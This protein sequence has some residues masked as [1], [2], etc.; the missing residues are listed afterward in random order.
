MEAEKAATLARFRSEMEHAVPWTARA[1]ATLEKDHFTVTR[2]HRRPEKPVWFV[3]ASPPAEVQTGFGL[4]PEL[5]FVLVDHEVQA[6]DVRAAAEEVVRSE[7][8]LDGNLMVVCDRGA[9]LQERLANIGG[10]GQRI[11]W[12]PNP[13]GE[14]TSLRSVL[15]SVLPTYDAYEERDPVRGAQLVGREAE[16]GELLTR[17]TRG[18][19]VGLFGLRKMGKTSLFRAVT[20]RLDPA[21][22]LRSSRDDGPTGSMV[23][24]VLDAGL[25][26]ERSVDGLADELLVALE[27]R[28]RAAGEA[29]PSRGRQGLSGWKASVEALLDQGRQVCVVIDEY[30]LLFEGEG[31]E[32]AV[33]GLNRLFRLH[34]GW[35]QTWQGQVS[36][37]LVGRDSTYLSAPEVDGVTNALLAWCTPTWLG[38][39]T[40]PKATEL[41]R[42]IG[43]RVGLDVGSESARVAFDWTGGHPLLQR[44]FGSALRAQV[45]H[46]DASWKA[47]TDPYV[48]S[49]VNAY[50]GRDA[51]LEVA[52]EVVAL[53]LKRHPEGYVLLRELAEGHGWSD[54]VSRCGGPNGAA[55]RT[56]TNF[57]LA[58]AERRL[59]ETLRWYVRDLSPAP[60]SLLRAS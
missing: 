48:P 54:A 52:R 12:T 22:A 30:D 10:P 25:L 21:S 40:R 2:V 53:L 3:W 5:L 55:A 31:G 26:V 36:L 19:A 28:M 9:S 37:V 33:P 24:M 13:N 34:R 14:W 15:Q 4:A 23:A 59:S 45:R 8:R 41:L 18:D 58:S 47:P 60:P 27:R 42:K 49:T 11:A 43:R 38:P 35:A 16:V 50:R 1:L 20:D 6:I 51:V 7:L 56:L 32:G 39:L 57:G 29:T 46:S 17:V 44:Q